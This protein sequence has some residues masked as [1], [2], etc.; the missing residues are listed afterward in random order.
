MR[1]DKKSSVSIV[2]SSCFGWDTTSEMIKLIEKYNIDYPMALVTAGNKDAICSTIKGK[3]I[4]K[5]ILRKGTLLKSDSQLKD[6]LYLDDYLLKNW[7][8]YFDQDPSIII[9]FPQIPQFEIEMELG[10]NLK[11]KSLEIGK[12]N[13]IEQSS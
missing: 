9:Y 8:Y 3:D 11:N 10:I 5:I 12:L 6:F 4:L 13:Q 7:G 1:A 2:V